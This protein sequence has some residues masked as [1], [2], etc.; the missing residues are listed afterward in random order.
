ML[1]LGVRRIEIGRRIARANV[2][3]GAPERNVRSMP[4]DTG[5]NA[6]PWRTKNKSPVR[7]M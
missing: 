6:A 3:R 2:W 7:K 1:T 5:V 4:R